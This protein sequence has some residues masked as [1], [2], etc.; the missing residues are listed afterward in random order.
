MDIRSLVR[1]L[2]TEATETNERRMI[3]FSGTQSAGIDAAY[4]AIDAYG[5]D[6]VH[7]VTEQEGFRYDRLHPDQ[8]ATL[9]G[10]T[11]EIV[12]V[13]CHGKWTPD[14]IGQTVGA[15]DGGG[16]YIMLT[17]PLDDWNQQETSLATAVVSPP[18][19]KHDVG[20]RFL[21]RLIRL[22][23][24]HPGI[25]IVSV[26]E[27]TR[28]D[29]YEPTSTNT[30][31]HL[32]PR[33]PT[34]PQFPL[35]VYEQC[36]T[37]DQVRAVQALESLA[38]PN[39]A[40]V[41]EADRGRG[42]STA[43]GFAAAALC[44]DGSDVTV[45]A[46]TR[47][48]A[49]TLLAAAAETIE[50]LDSP[51]DGS[52]S[53]QPV[54]DATKAA[55]ETSVLFVEE[56]AALP[57]ET[58]TKL[59]AATSIAFST[60]VRGYEGTGRGFTIRFREQLDAS[61]HDIQY[62]TLSEP[63]RYAGDD[64]IEQWSFRTLLLDASPPV[65]QAVSEATPETVQYQQ[66]T[67]DMLATDESLLRSVFGLLVSAHYRTTPTDLLRL[68][69]APNASVHAL[70]HAGHPVSVA[71]VV[72]EGGLDSQTRERLFRGGRVAGN[73]VPDILT[74]HLRDAEAGAPIG[75]RIQRIATH[76]STQNRGLASA[77]LAEIRSTYQTQCD[78]LSVSFGATP[79]LVR[80]WSRNGF[81]TIHLA[82][83]QNATSGKY[84]VLLVDPRSAAGEQ[85]ADRHRNW[86]LDRLR[87]TLSGPLSSMDPDVVAETLGGID[88]SASDS[89]PVSLTD[90][91]WELVGAVLYGPGL[92]AAGP[93]AFE[94]L[95]CA[96]LIDP[97]SDL[98][99]TDRHIL[100]R[101]VLQGWAWEDI[102]TEVGHSTT[103]PTKRAIARGFR[104]IGMRFGGDR[105][106]REQARYM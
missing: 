23:E 64:P 22:L 62:C 98:T 45:T 57:V 95:L 50:N 44:A 106:A 15:V 102:A 60:T 18:Y 38:T 9:L 39:T 84:S 94:T 14:T 88:R 29:R 75:K 63:I 105:L 77:L 92:L 103:R 41:I 19:T 21:N 54:E 68:L 37:R 24:T 80:F 56:A 104:P 73:L 6:D 83:T 49:A 70:L 32:Q 71:L 10:Q 85:L 53:F 89:V 59:T 99:S 20:C 66:L 17:P 58:L 42:K 100:I 25:S 3:V 90:R 76:T 69:D 51:A 26:D 11:R 36:L 30:A 72:E 65:E 81:Q 31:P 96:E 97:A 82:T 43:C 40:I 55:N 12:V 4:T 74:S 28:I 46:P 91:Q 52:I 79:S 78:Y 101:R 27:D 48:H 35:R 33:V 7:L 2:E 87:G 47:D 13:D 93:T 86:L 16:L 5:T 8:A 34:Q 67:Q 1:S 61:S